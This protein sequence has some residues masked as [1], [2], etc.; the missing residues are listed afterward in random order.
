MITFIKSQYVH[1]LYNKTNF[2][3]KVNEQ[4]KLQILFW[5]IYSYTCTYLISCRYYNG[6]GENEE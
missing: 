3:F 4:K 2:P 1:N 5:D 6:R